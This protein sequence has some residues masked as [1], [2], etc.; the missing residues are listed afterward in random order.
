MTIIVPLAFN[1]P[2]NLLTAQIKGI[3]SYISNAIF[4][5]IYK[6]DYIEQY[7]KYNIL[8]YTITSLSIIIGCI[9]FGFITNNLNKAFYIMILIST[10]RVFI[11]TIAKHRSL[12]HIK[13]FNP[14]IDA[15]IFASIT[16]ISYLFAI[17][18]TIWL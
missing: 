2:L 18:L 5:I 9:L 10:I 14:Y 13:S 17:I 1:Q 16:A 3:I 6:M 7:D 4:G 15:L 11:E 8:L 12:K